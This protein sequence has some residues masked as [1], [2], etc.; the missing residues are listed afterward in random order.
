MKP[1]SRVEP[2]R[3]QRFR[4]AL[5]VAWELL[6]GFAGERAYEN[7]LTHQGEHHPGEPVLNERAFWRQHIDR[8]DRECQA[9]CC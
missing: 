8:G 4:N 1:A 7:Y 2:S 3:P 9:R 5:Q 6:R